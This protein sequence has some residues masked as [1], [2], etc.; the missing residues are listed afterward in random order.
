[1]WKK[2]ANAGRFPLQTVHKTARAKV[3]LALHVTGQRDDGYHLLDS[4]VV[5]SDYG[6]EITVSRRTDGNEHK[7]SITGPFSDGLE[8]TDDNL[9]LKAVKLFGAD[10]P[11]LDLSLVKKLPVASGIGG[12]SAD[13]AAT[14]LAIS[15]LL[16]CPHP[17]SSDLLSLGADVPVCVHG[18][19]KGS[20]IH[21][22]GIGET[23]CEL[24]KIP[25]LSLLLVNPLVQVSTPAIF[26]SLKRKDNP[27]LKEIPPSFD[28]QQSLVEWLQQSRNDL[29]HPAILN[30]ADVQTC[31]NAIAECDGILL[32]RMSGSGATCFGLFADEQTAEKAANHL[33]E[34]HANW[35]AVTTKLAG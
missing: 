19:S 10:L 7:L 11:A 8:T 12:G 1:M 17:T 6:D 35:W 20:A 5:F 22:R 31:L 25:A 15:E 33:S 9:V 3:N 24:P 27:P 14:M 21:M 23:L 29:Q 34:T 26:T 30:C 16:G 13:A 32:S 28:H 18:C 2:T 4:V